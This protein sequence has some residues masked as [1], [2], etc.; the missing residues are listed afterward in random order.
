MWVVNTLLAAIRPGVLE[1]GT[2]RHEP[3][4]ALHVGEGRMPLVEVHHGRAL[5]HGVEREHAAHPQQDLL[6][7]AQVGAAL[8]QALGQPRWGGAPG[9]FV[10]S[11]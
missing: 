8:V 1:G 2:P 3:A 6:P 11:R 10:S 9:R 7:E 5:A 4:H